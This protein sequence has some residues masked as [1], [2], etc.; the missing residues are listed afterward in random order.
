MLM[1]NA[2][3]G[4]TAPLTTRLRPQAARSLISPGVISTLKSNLLRVARRH[5]VPAPVIPSGDGYERSTF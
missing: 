5:R 2:T 1:G 4:T 3:G